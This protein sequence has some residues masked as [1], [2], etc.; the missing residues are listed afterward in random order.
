MWGV[1]HCW[2]YKLPWEEVPN[3]DGDYLCWERVERWLDYR[4]VKALAYQE[5]A[6]R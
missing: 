2:P 4:P 6:Q 3:T 1:K 5:L